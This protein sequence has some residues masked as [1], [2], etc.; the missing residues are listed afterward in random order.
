MATVLEK[1]DS[2]FLT[3]AE[4]RMGPL[5]VASNPVR[6]FALGE[7][8]DNGPTDPIS[9]KIE[10]P[11]CLIGIDSYTAQLNFEYSCSNGGFPFQYQHQCFLTVLDVDP[12]WQTAR[13]NAQTHLRRL[14]DLMQYAMQQGQLLGLTDDTNTEKVDDSPS[15]IEIQSGVNFNAGWRSGA[16]WN[17]TQWLRAAQ[18]QFSITSRDI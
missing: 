14:A 18:I 6:S 2:W 10:M 16:S 7:L 13:A 17:D 9:N 5:A 11:Y 3:N 8:F 12:D 1:L 4:A 15:A